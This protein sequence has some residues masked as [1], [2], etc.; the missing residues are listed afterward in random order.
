M[1]LYEILLDESDDTMFYRY[2]K[3]NPYLK[4]KINKIY[5]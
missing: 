3:T 5:R 1:D 2:Y 4:Y